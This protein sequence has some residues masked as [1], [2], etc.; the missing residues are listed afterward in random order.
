MVELTNILDVPKYIKGIKVVIFDMDDTLYSEKEYVRSGYAAVA[1][2]FPQVRDAETKLW[3]LFEAREPA[4]DIF[5]KQEG[6]YSEELKQRCLHTYRF[7]Q[8]NI[9]L[10]DGVYDMLC[11]LKKSYRLGLITDGRPEGQWAKI[12]ALQIEKLFDYMLVTDE[13]GG[14]QCRKPNTLAFQKMQ[15][16]FGTEYAQM[17]YIGD[18]LR[19]DFLAPQKLGMRSIYFNNEEGLY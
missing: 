12:R 8:P 15:E 6:L 18:N 16:H 7:H 10:Y 1:K 9:H 19:K 11:N 4:I 13:L 17:C 2:L 5:L 14:V 3:S